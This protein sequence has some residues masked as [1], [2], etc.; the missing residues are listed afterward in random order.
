LSSA[1][2]AGVV[3]A[4]ADDGEGK[5]VDGVQKIACSNIRDIVWEVERSRMN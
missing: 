1:S 2:L 3:C 4:I 5:H